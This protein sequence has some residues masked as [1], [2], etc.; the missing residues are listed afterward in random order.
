MDILCFD[1]YNL[2]LLFVLLFL[3]I[4][5]RSQKI[6]HGWC[7]YGTWKEGWIYGWIFRVTWLCSLIDLAGHRTNVLTVGEKWVCACYQRVK[8]IRAVRLANGHQKKSVHLEVP[9]TIHK[10]NDSPEECATEV[11]RNL[12][13]AHMSINLADATRRRVRGRKE[14]L[15]VDCAFSTEIASP[16]QL[17]CLYIVRFC[18]F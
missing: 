2:K 16:T 6:S 4:Y 8:G 11:C 18:K 10:P 7:T 13:T 15:I 12:N 17:D 1:C 14:F 9:A 3:N 5:S